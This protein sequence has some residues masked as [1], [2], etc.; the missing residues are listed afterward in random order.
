[1]SF[2]SDIH[3]NVEGLARV[4]ATAEQLV[5]L[6]DLL[7]YVDYHEHGRGILG[8]VFGADRVAPFARLRSAG[9]F[10]A[11]RE[12]NRALWD[13]VRDPVGLLT[14]VVSRRYSEIVDVLPP[15]TLLTLGNVDVAAVWQD[16]AGE[17][18]P[19]LD[20]AVRTVA[21][22]RFG[23][24]AGGSSRPG[25]PMRP[26]ETVWQP[27]VRPAETYRA[28][29][30]ALEPVDVLCAH[31]PPDLPLLRY[32]VVPARLEMYGPGLLEYIDRHRPAMALFGHVH[33]PL[34]RRA[35]R[36]RT[37]CLNVGHF[38]RFPTAFDVTLD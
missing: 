7:D 31:L 38:Q 15:G 22:R 30:D 10:V 19:F 20:G 33:Q 9:D 35:R 1:M 36:G 4:A 12:Y 32:D 28:V 25:V 6:G 14:E 24:V 2:V 21:G 18:M 23:F 16:V 17:R 34:S 37:E 3:G 11:L 5:V 27:L 8:T 29:V 13:T 26:P